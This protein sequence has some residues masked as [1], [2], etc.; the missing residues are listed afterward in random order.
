[1][2]DISKAKF[3]LGWEPKMNIEQTVELTVDW[4]K[5]YREE[6]VYDVCVDQ[7]VNFIQ[8]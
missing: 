8:K 4:Y 3:R 2:L 5:R 1:M 7:I 6:E